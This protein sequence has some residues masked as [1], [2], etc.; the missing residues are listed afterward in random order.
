MIN[1]KDFEQNLL[2]VDKK[3]YKNIGIYSIGYIT[4]KDS[5]HAEIKSVNLLYIIINQAEGSISAKIRINT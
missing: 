2:K 4:M 1:I 5:D 3:T